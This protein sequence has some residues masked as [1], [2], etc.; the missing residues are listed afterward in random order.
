MSDRVVVVGIDEAGYGPLLGPLV[1]SATAFELPAELAG[2]SLW[3]LLAHSVAPA[4]RPRDRRLPIVDSKKLYHRG[5]GLARLERS[6]LAAIAAAGDFPRDTDHLW[7]LVAP[8]LPPLLAQYPWYR[9]AALPLPVASDA[10]GTRLA[11]RRLRD[12]A[13]AHGVVS[14][15]V[16]CEP[17]LE[18]HY[19]RLVASTRNKAVVLFGLTTRLIQRV[20]D[21]HPGHSLHIF[22]DKQGGRGHYGRMLMRAFDDRRLVVLEES[23]AHSAYELRR[24]PAD[25]RVAFAQGGEAQHL[26]IAL[27]SIVCKYVR[28]LLMQAFNAWWARHAPGVAATA[29]YYQDGMRFIGEVRPHFARLSI[30]ERWMIRRQ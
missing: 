3:E 20:A 18:G 12:D 28:E 27:A 6:A 23:D 10:G 14:A 5:D 24:A 19:N 26:P 21:A 9:E 1:V 29:G 2:R 17:L 30:D 11:A 4:P 16:Y 13:A 15:G 8:H 22:A 7:Q 25:W